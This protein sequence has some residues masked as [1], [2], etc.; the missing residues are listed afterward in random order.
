MCRFDSGE[1]P[2]RFDRFSDTAANV[3]WFPFMHVTGVMH[4]GDGGQAA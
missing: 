4:I 3:L 1:T 2:S